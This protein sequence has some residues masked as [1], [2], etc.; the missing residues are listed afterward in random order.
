MSLKIEVLSDQE[1]K[2]LERRQISFKVTHAKTATPKRIDIRK[3][4]ADQL[5]VDPETIILRPLRQ[6]YGTNESDGTAFLYKSA[7]RG[8]LIERD[9]LSDRLKPKEKK[10]EKKEEKP[11][12]EKP[13]KEE[14]KEEKKAEKKAEKKE[15]KKD[16]K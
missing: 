8:H 4:L 2:L 6:K 12:V 9:Y 14:K 13:P 11:V 7:D 3:E 1:D 15:E 16:V 5:R 10:E